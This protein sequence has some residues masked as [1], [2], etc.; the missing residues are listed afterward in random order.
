MNRKYIYYFYYNNIGIYIIIPILNRWRTSEWWYYNIIYI[1]FNS[2]EIVYLHVN[3]NGN[4]S[5]STGSFKIFE[6]QNKFSIGLYRH[7]SISSDDPAADI[8][9]IKK[10]SYTFIRLQY[11]YTL[12]LK[13]HQSSRLPQLTSLKTI[14]FFLNAFS[15]KVTAIYFFLRRTMLYWYFSNEKRPIF[16]ELMIYIIVLY[17][18]NAENYPLQYIAFHTVCARDVGVN[19]CFD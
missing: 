3:R 5:G 14:L 2:P 4:V 13:I 9:G 8:D 10:C 6:T 19:N 1:G 12:E 11:E 18:I 15:E 16:F 7:R 17:Y